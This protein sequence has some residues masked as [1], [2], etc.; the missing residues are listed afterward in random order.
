[1]QQIFSVTI[2]A[3]HRRDGFSYDA[4]FIFGDRLFVGYIFLK[5]LDTA[6]IL[7]AFATIFGRKSLGFDDIKEISWNIFWG[8]LQGHKGQSRNWNLF[9]L[10]SRT[11]DQ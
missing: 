7:S 3:L 6:R 9:L 1:V 10:S 2:Y 4:N 8:C 5:L 11:Y